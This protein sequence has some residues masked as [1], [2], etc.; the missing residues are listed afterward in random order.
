MGLFKCSSLIVNSQ[1]FNMGYELHIVR[2]FDWENEENESNISLEEWLAYIQTDQ[3]LELAD[4]YQIKLKGTEHI[5][6][7]PGFCNW[8]G[9]STRIDDNKPWFDYG[10]G[11]ISTKHPDDETI[12]KMITIAQALNGSVQGDDGEPYDESYFTPGHSQVRLNTKTPNKKP[13]WKFW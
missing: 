3:E 4:G 1:T 10:N 2:D 6:N 5:Q 8:N 13:W 9:H 11:M 12:R 7:A